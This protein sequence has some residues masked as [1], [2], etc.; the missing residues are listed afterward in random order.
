MTNI[1]DKFGEP[2]NTSCFSEQNVERLINIGKERTYPDSSHLFWEG[3]LSDKLFLLKSGRVKITKSTDE[4]KEL[5]L[6]MY[7][8]GDLVGQVDPFH[9]TKH[10][11]TA[12]VLEEAEVLLIEQKDIEILICQHCD[13]S[14]DFMKW[15]GIHHRLTQTKFRDLMMYGKPGAL[16]STLIRLSN[17]Y[18]EE[19]EDGGLLINKKITHT[20]LS[21]MIGA[22]RESVNRMLSD[23]RKRDVIEYE[24]GMIVIR[25][26]EHLREVCHCEMCPNEICRI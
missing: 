11:F 22:T 9:S 7:Q 5:I 10:T 2:C 23:L 14:I 25:E 4:G 6:Y 1:T 12:E 18:G 16:C 17:T 8:A 13:F 20:D 15:M 21:N 19:L 3:D 24:N 26:L